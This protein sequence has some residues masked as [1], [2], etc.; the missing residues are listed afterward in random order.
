MRHHHGGGAVLFLARAV[1]GEVAPRA[2]DT[3]ASATVAVVVSRGSARLTYDL[4]YHG[5]T[6]GA[7]VRIALHNFGRG[8]N[9][10]VVALI[11][12]AGAAA[13][14]ATPSARLAGTLERVALPPR[15]LSEF[16]SG[17]IYVEVDVGEGRPEIRGQLEPNGAMVPM[18]NFIAPLRPTGN[19]AAT[20]E[21]TA[22]LSETY[23]PDGKVEVEYSVTVAG[24]S[25]EPEAVSVTGVPA[26]AA[27][28]QMRFLSTGRL[29]VDS[30]RF[31]VRRQGGG[32]FGGR[33][34]A[35]SPTQKSQLTLDAY[36]MAARAPAL[37]VRTSRFPEGE[38][39]GVFRPVE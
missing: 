11:C 30:R 37:V 31:G 38:L 39:A 12:G 15:L 3:P 34:V 35:A 24:T 20:G 6:G 19:G 7:P 1:G 21:G 9:G 29:P 22:V 25:G 33:Y 8:G 27:P 36:F 10:P 17:R 4:T 28:P 14:P 32:S 18:R 13:C 26:A 16:A 2:V 5:L 23:L